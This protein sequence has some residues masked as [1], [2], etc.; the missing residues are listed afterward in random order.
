[1]ESTY[2]LST[3]CSRLSLSRSPRELSEILRD[4]RTSTYEICRIEEK[5]NQT[6]TFHKLICNMTPEFRWILKIL[7]KRGEIVIKAM[8]FSRH[9]LLNNSELLQ[10]QYWMNITLWFWISF[11][12][13][14]KYKDPSSSSCQNM[15]LTRC[16][17]WYNSNVCI[18]PSIF[19]GIRSKVNKV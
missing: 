2:Y 16:C 12:Y 3:N 6:T 19:Y 8:P 1:M 13:T 4:I 14:A 9:R 17:Y 10:L 11:N 15:V 7:W 18:T 5:I